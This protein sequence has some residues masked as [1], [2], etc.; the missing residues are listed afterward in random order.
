MSW[1]HRIE[2]A[3]GP[4]TT[5]DGRGLLLERFAQEFLETQNF[6]VKERVRSTGMEIDL[7]AADRQTGETVLIECKAHRHNLAAEGIIKLLGAVDFKGASAG[8]L[9]TTSDFSKDGRGVQDE[10]EQRKPEDRRK[11]RLYPPDKLVASLISAKLIVS[12]DK[13]VLP[14]DLRF[15]NVAYLLITPFG[16]FWSIEV[17]D[18]QTRVRTSVLTFDAETGN[19]VA[20]QELIDQLAQTDS[21]L[22]SLTWSTFGKSPD[23]TGTNRILDEL[24]NIVRVPAADKW[25]DYRPARPVDFVGRDQLQREVFDLFDLVRRG[26]T[27]TRLFAIKGPSGWG[28]SSCVLKIAATAGR[29]GSKKRTFVYSVDSRAANSSRFGELALHAAFRDAVQSGFLDCGAVTTGGAGDPF[30]T[31]SGQ[32]ALNELSSRQRV[33]CLIFD[34]FE[35]LLL[36]EGLE[37][38]FVQIGLLCDAVVQAQA[39]V[40]IGF[41]WKTDGSITTDHSAYHLWHSLADRRRELEL[42]PFNDTEITKVLNRF[43]QE[44]GQPLAPQLRRLLNDHCQ[45]FPWLLKKLCIHVLEQIQNGSDQNDVLGQKLSIE[46]LFN[47]DL[48]GLDAQQTSCIR[49]VAN[50]SPADFFRV[51]E[52]FGYE[53]V[54]RLLDRRLIVRTGTKLTIYWDIFRDY[55]VTNRVPSIPITYLP[56]ANFNSYVQAVRTLINFESTTYSALAEELNVAEGTIDNIVRDLVMVGHAQANRKSGTVKALDRSESNAMEALLSF[57]RSHACYLSLQME[58]GTE[59]PITDPVVKR[60]FERVYVGRGVSPKLIDAYSRRAI[61]WLRGVGLLEL[62]GRELYFQS[63]P[64]AK[65]L[66]DA[67]SAL[68]RNRGTVFIGDAPPESALSAVTA[69]LQHDLQRDEVEK[70]FGRNTFNALLSLGLVDASGQLILTVEERKLDPA[71]LL[72][73]AAERSASIQF[74]R[75]LITTKPN[76]RGRDVGDA[77]ALEF[78]ATWSLGSKLRNGNALRNWALWANGSGRATKPPEPVTGSLFGEDRLDKH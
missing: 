39:N 55:L 5:S 1:S 46:A 49:R 15:T 25:A 32:A 63:K 34:Q 38:V 73:A 65:G 78:K 59:E 47:A 43:A 23:V 31:E 41:S 48:Q 76:L 45:G 70:R 50:D 71:A 16:R 26:Q 57:W 20:S 14:S 44:L 4:D 54:T 11:L 62:R 52:V 7:L 9:I 42:R 12:P 72:G 28:K 2:I 67:V 18:E 29:P 75:T 64:H 19:G 30:G 61:S 69:M 74:V 10:W 24:Q 21:S 6:D 8:W 22:S 53:V 37:P 77:V 35:E 17:A 3:V 40:V 56:T 68:Q 66:A 36:K 33:I 51:V 13:L 27:S 58:V 60:V